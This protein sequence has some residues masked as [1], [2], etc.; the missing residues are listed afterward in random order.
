[1]HTSAAEPS[2]AVR[3]QARFLNDLVTEFLIKADCND[4]TRQA[5]HNRL[6]NYAVRLLGSNLRNTRAA[7]VATVVQ[8]LK[9]RLLQQ[10][11]DADAARLAFKVAV[12]GCSDVLHKQNANEHA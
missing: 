5:Y 3:H 11:R 12:H 8:T 10:Q 1:M 4:L 7:D 9:S 6:Y 2:V